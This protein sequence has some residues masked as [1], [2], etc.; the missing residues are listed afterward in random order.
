LDDKL[1]VSNGQ[2]ITPKPRNCGLDVNS[3]GNVK[4][5]EELEKNGKEATAAKQ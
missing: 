2:E 5:G 1:P 3:G 4:D